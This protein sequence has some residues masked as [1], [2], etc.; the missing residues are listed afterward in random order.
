MILDGKCAPSIR[1]AAFKKINHE[2]HND[3]LIKLLKRDNDDNDNIGLLGTIVH[4]LDFLHHGDIL[5]AIAQHESL[6][7]ATRE[8]AIRKL[9]PK[10]HGRILSK[11]ARHGGWWLEEAAVRRLDPKQH[12]RVL[13]E[14]VAIERG[15]GN[16]VTAAI[17]RLRLKG[18]SRLLAWKATKRS[19]CFMVR[20]AAINKLH[21]KRHFKVLD[22][23]AKDDSDDPEIRTAAKRRKRG[24][25]TRYEATI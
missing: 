10:R 7:D 15:A 2:R 6:D 22:R 3:I 11:I 20:V 25:L 12:D 16:V 5:A 21:P 19:E 1:E 8:D 18:H 4:K 23:I 9:S 17:G 14:I 13:A 24:L